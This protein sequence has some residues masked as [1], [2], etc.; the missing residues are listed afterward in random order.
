MDRPS[1]SERQVRRKIRRQLSS[2][3]NQT[4]ATMQGGL[5]DDAAVRQFLSLRRQRAV[6]RGTL[7]ELS[8]Q[9][10]SVPDEWRDYFD[11][12]A[13]MPGFVARDVPH[14]PVVAA[15]AEQAKQG[16]FPSCRL[17]WVDNKE[18]VECPAADQRLPLHGCAGQPRSLKTQRCVQVYMSW[19]VLLRSTDADKNATFNVGSFKGVP[20]MPSSASCSKH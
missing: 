12:L 10:G 15:F 1:D 5:H 16:R 14:A 13:Q 19:A 8:R 20:S 17:T 2:I 7:R 6:R 9:S 4:P 18:Q 11:K 3:Q